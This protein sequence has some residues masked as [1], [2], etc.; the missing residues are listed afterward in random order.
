MSI[1]TKPSVVS[2]CQCSRTCGETSE[3]QLRGANFVFPPFCPK[4]QDKFSKSWKDV[5][6][7]HQGLKEI[8]SHKETAV[9]MPLAYE[10]TH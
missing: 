1:T 2:A 9:R 3:A 4:K 10:T 8:S 5:E 6:V 7:G